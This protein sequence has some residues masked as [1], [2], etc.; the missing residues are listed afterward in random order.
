MNDPRRLLDDPSL[1]Q[2]VDRQ[3]DL[4][5]SLL[6]SARDVTP[7]AAAKA[8]IWGNLQNLIGPPPGGGPGQSGPGHSPGGPAHVPPGGPPLGGP[9]AGSSALNAAPR[10]SQPRQPAA[11]SPR[12]LASLACSLAALF[13]GTVASRPEP[14]STSPLGGDRAQAS[15]DTRFTLPTST[16]LKRGRQ[17]GQEAPLA[18]RGAPVPIA[19]TRSAQA[20][21]SNAA[22]AA[23]RENDAVK[24]AR[25]RLAAGRPARRSPSWRARSRTARHPRTERQVLAIKRSPRQPVRCPGRLIGVH[26]RSPDQPY[27]VRPPLRSIVG[28]GRDSWI[29]SDRCLPMDHLMDRTL[30]SARRTH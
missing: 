10:R 23:M 7:P 21:S 30:R 14:R 3:G 27:A 25:A 17:R 5:R 24:R 1:L 8:R 20:S 6:E 4:A 28:C 2:S 18:V 26:R 29:A 12:S 9:M 22:G 11:R 15:P 16:A 19:E 13:L